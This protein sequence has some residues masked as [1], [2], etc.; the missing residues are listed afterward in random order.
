VE[1]TKSSQ[2]KGGCVKHARADYNDRIQDS[3]KLIPENEPVFL[4]RGQDQ[5]SADAV[6]AWAHLHRNNGGSDRVY[7]LAM[8]HAD[9]M[10]DWQ[11]TIKSKKA[12]VPEG[13]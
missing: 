12:D 11:R 5:V 10:E 6:R 7:E 4:I 8:Q 9:L 2:D 13:V 1:Q 3:A